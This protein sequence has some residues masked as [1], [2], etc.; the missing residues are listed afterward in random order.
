MSSLCRTCLTVTPTASIS[1]RCASCGSPKVVQHGELDTLSLAHIDCD[2]FYAAVEKRDDPSIRNKPVIIGGGQRG[3]VTT[4]CYLARIQGVR[5]AM[6][7]Y[8]AKQLCPQ[9]VIVKPNMAKYRE[10]GL[11]VR[12]YFRALTPDVEP[13]S[14]DEAFLDLSGIA[15]AGKHPAQEL[16]RLAQTVQDQVGITLSIGLSHNKLLAKIASDLDKPDGFA[17]LGQAEAKDFLADKPVKLIWGVGPATA[18]R[19]NALGITRIAQLRA[20]PKEDMIAMFGRFGERLYHFCR[21]EDTR[22]VREDRGSKSVS[23]ET[24]LM[25]D[26]GDLAELTAIVERLS[27][28]VAER[29]STYELAGKRITL[30]LK[31]TDFDILSRSQTLDGHTADARVLFSVAQRLLAAEVAREPLQTY[32]LLGVGV[33]GFD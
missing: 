1:P 28:R 21:G 10:T 20:F 2:A 7:M 23:S 25:T 24:T 22:R 27:Y 4:A 19:M 15:R 18:K 6:P 17:I 12:Q 31:T 29:L 14:I 26:T 8:R 3:V 9:A 5:S 13:L 30:K 16:A 33:A 32:R 11:E